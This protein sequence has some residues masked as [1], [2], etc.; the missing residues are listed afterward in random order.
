VVHGLWGP[1][2][3]ADCGKH[4]LQEAKKLEAELSNQRQNRQESRWPSDDSRTVAMEV[5]I[6]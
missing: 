5:G 3:W 4:D 1:H 2:Q 6:R